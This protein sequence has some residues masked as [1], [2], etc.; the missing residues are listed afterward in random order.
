MNKLSFW[1]CD[2]NVRVF[3]EHSVPHP[4][5][6][7]RITVPLEPHNNLAPQLARHPQKL[8]MLKYELLRPSV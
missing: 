4:D 8:I 3:P 1:Q 5:I 7:A 2:N 6:L